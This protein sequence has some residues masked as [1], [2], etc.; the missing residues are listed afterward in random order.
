[1]TD[2]EAALRMTMCDFV[3]TIGARRVIP[4][5]FHVG[6]LGRRTGAHQRAIPEDPRWVHGL[7]TDL[8]ERALDALV[9]EDPVGWVT[10]SGTLEPTDPDLAWFAATRE[11]FARHELA[12]PGFFVITRS[13][14]I[15]LTAEQVVPNRG[16]RPRRRYQV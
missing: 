4:T 14:W 7:R 13:G 2:L 1:M 12:L 3:R 8:V 15:D 11:A 5:V 6:K 9:C 10:R 16:A